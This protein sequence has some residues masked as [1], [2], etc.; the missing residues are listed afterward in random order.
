MLL[1]IAAWPVVYSHHAPD[2]VGIELLCAP[3]SAPELGRHLVDL[4][5]KP[6]SLRV[7]RDLPAYLDSLALVFAVAP[8]G[9]RTVVLADL[10]AA[11]QQLDVHT[12]A[13]L[14]PRDIGDPALTLLLGLAARIVHHGP[15]PWQR[16][17][18]LW[19]REVCPCS[20]PPRM[21]KSCAA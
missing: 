1:L 9:A 6:V 15:A 17:L 16:D 3:L 19:L 7:A 5:V 4:V 14:W 20:A 13:P 18:L 8:A 2:Q 21:R 11:L 10:R 12:P